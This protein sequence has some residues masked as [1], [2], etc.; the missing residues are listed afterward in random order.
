VHCL[1]AESFSEETC[2]ICSDI[3]GSRDDLLHHLSVMHPGQEVP[4]ASHN[5]PLHGN[6]TSQEK[7][8][9]KVPGSSK[10]KCLKNYNN[11]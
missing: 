9:D 11:A 2:S 7:Y 4:S 6:V 10:G 3:F 5:K 1:Q 8:V